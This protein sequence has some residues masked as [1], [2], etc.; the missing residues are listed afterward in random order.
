MAKLVFQSE[1]YLSFFEPYFQTMVNDPSDAVLS[2]VAEVLIGVLVHD[3]D[4][5][6]ELFLQLCD[7]DER[8]L[9][10]PHVETFLQYATQ[11]HFGQLESLISQMIESNNHSVATAGA[12]WACCASLSVEE[13]VP[14][15][16]RCAA[17]S[18]AQRL[19]A[20]EVYSVNIKV[21]SLRAVCEEMLSELF[22]D[23]DPDVRQQARRCFYEFR[24]RDLREYE[25]LA[26]AYIDSP[27]FDAEYNPLFGALE[28]STAN[29]PGVILK[30]CDRVFELTGDELGDI[31]TAAAGTSSTMTK[32]VTRVY[33]RATD[34][35]VKS[36]CLDII[37]RMT[38]LGAYGLDTI[39]EEFDR[40][41]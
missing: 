40:E 38:V 26:E 20:A 24:G 41:I 22:S 29:V 39:T 11:T 2:C 25:S 19:G 14:L 16:R 18:K 7:D 37:D 35:S 13:A 3:R 33:S 15:A 30:A 28:E 4:L 23:P 34:P 10:T 36:H 12:R 9:A 5:A 6:V 1:R 21:S 31:S 32:L 17:G 27:A 8:L